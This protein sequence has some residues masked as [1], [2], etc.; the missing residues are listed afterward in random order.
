MNKCFAY[1][2]DGK[3]GFRC[4]A[5][6]TD[7]CPG[8]ACRFYKTEEQVAEEKEKT[9]VRLGKISEAERRRIKKKY[10]I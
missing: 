8:K 3:D 4:T 1:Q 7:I 2:N 6:D 5:L 10:S 9:Q